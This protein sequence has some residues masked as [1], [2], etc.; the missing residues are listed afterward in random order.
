[1]ETAYHIFKNHPNI[2]NLTFHIDPVIREKIMIG[3]D[4]PSFDSFKTIQ[5]EYLPMFEA[6]G[7]KINVEKM[8]PF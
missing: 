4:L 7:A 2:K 8:R 1:M 5:S 6:L 3:S